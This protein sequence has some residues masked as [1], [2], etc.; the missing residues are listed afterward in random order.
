MNIL[1]KQREYT[2]WSEPSMRAHIGDN[3]RSFTE[4]ADIDLGNSSQTVLYNYDQNYIEIN[5]TVV[6]NWLKYN[7]RRMRQ[8]VMLFWKDI[9]LKKNSI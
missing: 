3:P 1:I 6:L 7:F 8:K 2:G 5:R 4:I 9:L